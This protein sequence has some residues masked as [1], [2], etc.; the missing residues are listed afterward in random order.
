MIN[1]K[2]IT[3]LLV[4]DHHI[5]RQGLKTLLETEADMTVVGEAENGFEAITMCEELGPMIV[6]MDIAL[7]KLNGIEA[8][9]KILKDHPAMKMLVLSAYADDRDIEKMTSLGVNGFLIKQCA[10][11]MLIEAIREIMKGNTF[12]SSSVSE[13]L[14]QLNKRPLRSE[15]ALLS[16]RE[17]QVLQL[18]TEGRANKE[19]A[20]ELE[21]SI[22]TVE[23][24]RQSIMKKLSIHDVAGLTRYAIAEGIIET[25]RKK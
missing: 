11:D 10:P 13:R 7:P 16:A 15:G 22:K 25:G 20:F 6:V 19:V 23:K 14:V 8:S 17:L 5:V 3:I 18:I 21:I 4:E 12:F 1:G 2:R 9:R 24:H